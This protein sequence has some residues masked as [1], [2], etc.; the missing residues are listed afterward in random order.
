MR[1][2]IPT[3]KRSN[4]NLTIASFGNANANASTS[5]M[6]KPN[7]NAST[8]TI[9]NETFHDYNDYDDSMYRVDSMIFESVSIPPR[10]TNVTPIPPPPPAIRISVATVN[11]GS[12]SSSES[13]SSCDS[14]RYL[15]D[16]SAFRLVCDHTKF[17]P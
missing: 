9:D 4:S 17:V 5:P 13:D 7:A 12:R 15:R 16:S 6:A 8:I 3:L 10:S 1:L 2:A 11:S 14:T